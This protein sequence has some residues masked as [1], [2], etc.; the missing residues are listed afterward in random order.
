MREVFVVFISPAVGFVSDLDFNCSNRCL[1]M[2]YCCF[3][4]FLVPC[5]WPVL[6]GVPFF[7]SVF[8]FVIWARFRWGGASKVAG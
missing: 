6:A 8:L 4:R 2:S 1:L 3:Q 5:L 7:G